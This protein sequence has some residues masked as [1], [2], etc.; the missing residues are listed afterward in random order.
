[1]NIKYPIWGDT[2]PFNSG[3]D[4]LSKMTV[5]KRHSGFVGSLR[6]I[7]TASSK[8]LAAKGKRDLDS[9][10]YF[11][12]MKK[13]LCS[14]KFDDVPT[15]TA[16]PVNGSDSAVII[17]PGGGYAAGNISS[18]QFPEDDGESTLTAKRL[19]E[20]GINAFVLGYR[21]NPYRMPAPLAD[22]QRAVR[23]L[24]SNC[25]EFGINPDK[26][27]LIGFSAGGYQAAGFINLLRGKDVLPENYRRD[28]VDEI[29]DS[30]NSAALFYPLID[31]SGNPNVL[32]AC[33]DKEDFDGRT[34]EFFSHYDLTK[35]INS[36]DVPQFIAHGTSDMLVSPD[37]S[38]KYAGLL[39]SD[40]GDAKFVIVPGAN[41]CFTHNKKY[42]YAFEQYLEW[43]CKKLEK[44]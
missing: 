31:F 33:F 17:I 21:Y 22:M 36:Y 30:I 40:G 23:W 15:L 4:K 12:F 44:R 14:E 13:G 32:Y 29:D 39:K 37:A 43:V 1:M 41:H 24:K 6:F 5:D 10:T 16:F 42:A 34:D 3:V 2:V 20:A 9:Y 38:E 7:K 35:N 11:Y 19:N 26:I 18:Q 25:T 27:G 28:A 8:K